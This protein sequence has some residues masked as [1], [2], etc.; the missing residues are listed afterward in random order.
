MNPQILQLIQQYLGQ[1]GQ[2]NPNLQ[3]ASRPA[4]PYE[5][6]KSPGSVAPNVLIGNS[7]SAFVPPEQFFRYISQGDH[8]YPSA[9]PEYDKGFAGFGPLSAPSSISRRS[10]QDV[11]ERNQEQNQLMQGLPR[12]RAERPKHNSK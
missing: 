1:M 11:S 2:P 4:V 6:S 7:G 3:Q 10:S 8:N 12:T 9:Y 5:Y